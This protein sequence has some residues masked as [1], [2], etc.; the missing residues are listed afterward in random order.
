[1]KADSS[2]E[3]RTYPLTRS[4]RWSKV[5]P[6][7]LDV[8]DFL[9]PLGEDPMPW[10]D[11]GPYVPR[12]SDDAGAVA[13][14]LARFLGDRFGIEADQP[15]LRHIVEQAASLT[16]S[17]TWPSNFTVE[18]PYAGALLRVAEEYRVSVAA[19]LR[20]RHRFD[21]LL[22]LVAL[23]LGV[24]L[25]LAGPKCLKLVLIADGVMTV[26][27]F[28]AGEPTGDPSPGSPGA[29]RARSRG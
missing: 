18:R 29:S 10:I 16:P 12:A 7:L 24:R 19:A 5:D 14:R 27:V 1:M 15:R 3:L 20:A 2:P 13:G 28:F 9:V 23:V 6:A 8:P 17:R 11:S 22:M 21:F 26:V 4:S 25:M